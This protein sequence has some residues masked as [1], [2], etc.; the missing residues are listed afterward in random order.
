MKYSVIIPVYNVEK[1][2]EKCL[3]SVL[4]QTFQ[5]F[6]MIIVIDGATDGSEAIAR[7]IKK[8]H[9]QADIQIIV[10]KNKGLGG[11]RN[12]G[13][14]YATGDYWLFIDSDDYLAADALEVLDRVTKDD[15][16]D[17]IY[18]NSYVVNEQGKVLQLL[19]VQSPKK[20]DT[21]LTE[22]P[23]LLQTY[24]AAWN[25]LYRR[26]LFEDGIRYQEKKWFE[27]L[28]VALKFYLKAERI[29]FI[30][31]AL[32]YYVQRKGSIM[33]DGNVQRNMEMLDIF[34]SICAYY[35]EQGAYEKFEKEIEYLAIWKI[36]ILVMGRI[37]M[38]DPKSK[39]QTELVTYMEAH[40]PNYKTNSY[41]TQMDSANKERVRL[42]T[43]RKFDDLYL[44]Y[45][46]KDKFRKVMKFLIPGWM[47]RIYY[48][49][50]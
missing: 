14:E 34:D 50:K 40:F 32:Y 36:L 6:Q 15:K 3:L 49:R 20:K 9:P 17:M 41:L 19:N 27:D 10:Q 29:L 8:E 35:K 18:F 37:N 38:A 39:L 13:M 24:P 33:S 21:C 46:R 26:N 45:A 2:L 28:D 43:E 4:N 5:D 1:Y 11:A 7:R 48:S 16:Y 44:R 31:D 23:E 30:E 22:S 42:A 12:T 47:A 25:K